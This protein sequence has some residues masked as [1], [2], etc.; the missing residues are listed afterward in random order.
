MMKWAFVAA[1]IS[2]LLAIAVGLIIAIQVK[3]GEK[4]EGQ[5]NPKARAPSPRNLANS[6][7]KFGTAVRDDQGHETGATMTA[8]HVYA[9]VWDGMTS[10]NECGSYTLPGADPK[11]FHALDQFYAAD[12]NT[13]WFIDTP[14]NAGGPDT[15]QIVGAD[16][17]TFTL[18]YSPYLGEF[19]D[20]YTKDKY[21]VFYF[22]EIVPAAD[23]SSFELVTRPISS[24]ACPFV[25][26]KDASDSYYR[27]RSSSKFCAGYDGY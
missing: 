15:Y 25:E 16:P 1:G 24:S 3:S 17:S 4:P 27:G 19:S 5:N 26:A 21:H 14:T 12:K 13:V 8:T 18:I 11:T 10:D 7:C 20:M 23:P 2:V 6:D 22:G 9:H